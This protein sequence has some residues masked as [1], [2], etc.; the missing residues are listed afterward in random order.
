MSQK[1]DYYEVLGVPKNSNKD[2][3]KDAYR[4]L[5]LQYHP[6]RNKEP[7]AEEKFK[8]IS[9]A[10]AVLSD[11]EKRLQYDQ[12]GHAGIGSRYT[13]ED[14]FRGVDFS[15]V[16]RDLG[17]GNFGLGGFGSIFERFFGGGR[18]RSEEVQGGGDLR[19]D[20][21]ISLEDAAFG[22]E[23]EIEIPRIETCN[24]CNG[25]GAQSGTS[26]RQCSKCRG[27]G[28]VQ[29]V[30]SS[31]FT[32]IITMQTCDSCHGR[33]MIIDKPCRNCQ[34]S[35]K[36]EKKRRI[37]VKIPAGVD[38]G[39]SLR[40]RGEGDAGS[41]GTQPGDLYIVIHVNPHRSFERQGNDIYYETDVSF[42]HLALGGEVK[43]PTLEGEASLKIPSGTQSE[44]IF[45]LRGRGI[46]NLRNRQRGDELVKVKVQVPKDLTDR[47]KKM[48]LE[49]AKE[50][51]TDLKK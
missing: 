30:R 50:M 47:Q 28:Q 19:F 44:T 39:F 20:L 16:F 26:P 17:S 23:R 32:R 22:I 9:E 43:V 42:F 5:A 18:S 27:S 2:D 15:D 14:I 41:H 38:E 49:L 36:E 48:L 33:G 29:Y 13:T 35:G 4:K 51:G 34:G 6:D 24:I 12:F 7:G 21:H 40:L 37:K 11:D 46:P 8:E 45:R 3:I 1:R 25:S 10:Y 31:G